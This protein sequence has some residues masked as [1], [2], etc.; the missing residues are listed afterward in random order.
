MRPGPGLSN[1]LTVLAV[2]VAG[3]VAAY[4]RSSHAAH[5]AYLE[6]GRKL[7]DARECARRGEWAPFLEACGIEERTARNMMILARAEL[8][9]EAIEERG[10]IRASLESLR[11]PVREPE[12][13]SDC[14]GPDPEPV[15]GATILEG[16]CLTVLRRG[17]IEAGSVHL[18]VTSPPYAMARADSYGGIPADEYAA[19]FLPRA[20]EFARILAPDGSLVVNIKEH[21]DR[22]ARHP[23]VYRLAL[24]MQEAGWRLVDE[25]QWHK[26]NPVPGHWPD[27]LRDGF[28]RCYHFARGA[29]KFR[30]DAV[31]VPAAESTVKHLEAGPALAELDRTEYPSG[32]GI[33][34]A[35]VY[36]TMVAPSNVIRLPVVGAATGHPAAYP[37][38]LPGFFVKLLTDPGDLV[39]DPFAGSGASLEAAQ[40]LGRR[41]IGIEIRSDYAS[42]ARKRLR[43][44]LATKAGDRFYTR[45]DVARHCVEVFRSVC[46]EHGVDLAACRWIEP[47]AGAGAFLQHFPEGRRTG[48][49]VEPAGDGIARADFLTWPAPSEPH[50]VAGN[51]PYG[52]QGALALAFLNRAALS[53]AAIGFILPK[54]FGPVHSEKS[55]SREVRGAV[56]VH[57]EELPHDAFTDEAGKAHRIPCYWNVYLPASEAAE[58]V[59]IDGPGRIDPAVEA[60]AEVWHVARVSRRSPRRDPTTADLY[61]RAKVFASGSEAGELRFDYPMVTSDYRE[62]E[63]WGDLVAVRIRGEHPGLARFLLAVPWADRAAP[64][65]GR[66]SRTLGVRRVKAA[67]GE[68][69][70][71]RQEAA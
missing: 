45:P 12:T 71:E 1:Y 4:K 36:R 9:P 44:A 42:L 66:R 53:A 25:Y 46:A 7:A 22:G 67:I 51:P 65:T 61:L 52:Q 41:A 2:E 39:L 14:E 30:P 20:A 38:S 50:V 18:V 57:S 49:D 59:R 6:A 64:D 43:P 13:V 69:L 26:T 3:E 34:K 54:S 32:V 15:E 10:G 48:I 33:R 68:W 60:A 31:K 23:Y 17:D 55:R 58:A 70:R 24:A 35:N 28:E 63:P 47:A 37:P 62:A 8:T 29:P 27:R 40:A 56:M 19:W 16:D 5:V 21:T 11:A